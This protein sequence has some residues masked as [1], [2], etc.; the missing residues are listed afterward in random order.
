MFN[1]KITFL[2][3]DDTDFLTQISRISGIF[4]TKH[5]KKYLIVDYAPLENRKHVSNGVNKFH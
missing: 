2:T 4:T 1:K 3:T 5:T